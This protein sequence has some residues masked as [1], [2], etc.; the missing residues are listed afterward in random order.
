[1]RL[2]ARECVCILQGWRRKRH[3]HTH[4]QRESLRGGVACSPSSMDHDVA[5]W[6]AEEVGRGSHLHHAS[7]IQ[8]QTPQPSSLVTPGVRRGFGGV[9]ATPS[10]PA[11]AL[12]LGAGGGDVP[13]PF[14]T[15]VFLRRAREPGEARSRLDSTHHPASPHYS[16]APLFYFI[17]YFFGPRQTAVLCCRLA[18]S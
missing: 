10:T 18:S 4:T 14:G 15:E 8:Q 6:V 17:F 13:T 9:P 1:M 7:R 12:G 16:L 5:S 2:F 3:T 11:T